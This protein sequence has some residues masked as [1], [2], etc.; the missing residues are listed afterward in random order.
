MF[1]TAF[2]ATTGAPLTEM[3]NQRGGDLGFFLILTIFFAVFYVLV[4][5]PQT[6][7]AKEHRAMLEKLTVGNEVVTHGGI[8]GLINKIENDF[9]LLQVNEQMELKLQKSAVAS[10]LPKGTLKQLFSKK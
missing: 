1:N 10:C 4:I 8:V 5:R 2:A 6:R 9:V 7:R 3:V